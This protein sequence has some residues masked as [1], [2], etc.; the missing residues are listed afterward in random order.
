MRPRFSLRAFFAF[1]SLVAVACAWCVLPSIAARRLVRAMA[2]GKYGA[3]DQMF[4][5]ERDRCLEQWNQEHWS[6]HASG[7]L[8][9]VTLGQL[10]HGRRMVNFNINYFALDQIVNRD[11]LILVSPLGASKPEMGPERYGSQIIDGIPSTSR[12]IERR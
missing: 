11:G 8:A 5:D 9:P 1:A 10:I 7:R 12:T 6:F 4:R 3:A 2:D